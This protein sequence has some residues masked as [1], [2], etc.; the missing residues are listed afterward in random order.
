MTVVAT[1]SSSFVSFTHG[2]DDAGWFE[3]PRM[4][5]LNDLAYAENIIPCSA[6]IHPSGKHLQL[7]PSLFDASMTEIMSIDKGFPKNALLEQ[8]ATSSWQPSRKRNILS[9]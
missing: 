1:K 7:R 5:I 6:D 8:A 9:R 3:T 4:T 2:R